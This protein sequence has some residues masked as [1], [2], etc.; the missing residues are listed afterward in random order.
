MVIWVFFVLTPSYADLLSNLE[1]TSISVYF[2]VSRGIVL[3]ALV[4]WYMF[5]YFMV[6]SSYSTIETTEYLTSQPKLIEHIEVPEHP[7]IRPS[8]PSII[9]EVNSYPSLD[10]YD[11]GIGEYNQIV[12]RNSQE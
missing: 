11:F 3:Y 8:A 10:E 12:L 4:M 6:L 5:M 9:P 2:L 1:D 7:I